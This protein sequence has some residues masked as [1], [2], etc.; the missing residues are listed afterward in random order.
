MATTI[1][2]QEVRDG[3][4]LVSDLADF[5][6][7]PGVNPLDLK[8]N[9]GKVKNGT[10]V[11]VVAAGTLTLPASQTSY[12]E[13]DA[14]G[15]VSQNISA[16][17]PGKAPIA[18]VTT[19]SGGITGITDSRAWVNITGGSA[20]FVDAATPAGTIDGTNDTFSLATTPVSGS[21]KLY[22]NGIQ[23][24]LGSDYTLSGTTITYV[25]GNIPQVGDV[26][27]ADYRV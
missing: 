16:F 4:V 19:N 22:K 7:S 10:T 15:V 20:N 9:G 23:Q 3:S 11:V 21:L 1:G 13:V 26:H 14:A 17:S 2:S 8:Y 24:I 12:I 5:H 6:V 27:R 25:A 18:V